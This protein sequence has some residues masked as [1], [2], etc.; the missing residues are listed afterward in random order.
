MQFISLV[1]S[2]VNKNLELRPNLVVKVS[3]AGLEKPLD[4]MCEISERSPAIFLNAFMPLRVHPSTRDI[5]MDI[6][7]KN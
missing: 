4:M 7:K 2:Q 5:M 1:T 6:L 3:I